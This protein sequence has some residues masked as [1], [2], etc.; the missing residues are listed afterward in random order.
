MYAGPLGFSP[1]MDRIHAQGVQA[2]LYL[3]EPQRSENLRTVFARMVSPREDAVFV[4]QYVV[5]MVACLIPTQTAINEQFSTE[6]ANS[7]SYPGLEPVGGFSSFANACLNAGLVPTMIKLMQ[8]DWS[9]DQ[10]RKERYISQYRALQGLCMLL[11]TGNVSEQ[12]SL[13]EALLKE[14]VVEIC[15]R[16]L[17]HRLCI[18]R[19]AAISALHGLSHSFLGLYISSSTAAHIVESVCTY[20]LRGPKHVV[21]QLNDS[22]TAWQSE[23]FSEDI[24]GGQEEIIRFVP[25]YYA[26]AQDLAVYTAH[27]ILCT[28]PS[29]SQDFCLAALKE[30]PHIL[31]LLLYCA[32]INRPT[33]YPESQMKATSL[34]ALIAL[35]QWPCHTV[36]GSPATVGMSTS[37]RKIMSQ[38]MSVLTSRPEWSD[39]LI[40]VWMRLQEEDLIHAQRYLNSSKDNGRDPDSPYMEGFKKFFRSRA[41][42][43]ASVLR[44]IATFTHA[45][46]PCGITNA[47]IE[48]FLHIAYFGCRKGGKD[49]KDCSSAV[50]AIGTFE[51]EE[52]VYQM[53]IG[54]AC[55]DQPDS[56]DSPFV[57]A[58][59][60]VLGPIALIRLFVV[61]AQRKALDS[62]QTLRKA[63][64]GLSSSTSLAQIQVIT[65]PDV[66]RRAIEISQVRILERLDTGR[67]Y[68]E[69]TKNYACVIF[70]SAAEL[71]AAVV[72][73]DEHTEGRYMAEARGARKQLVIALGNASQM[74]LKLEHYQ[75]ALRLADAAIGVAEN[76]P[77]EENLNP[78]IT[79][80]NKRRASQATAG[81]QRK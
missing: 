59:Q 7:K 45:A 6:M 18:M 20:A 10:V 81:L 44:L 52:D 49:I 69:D 63:P 39:K 65:H 9:G 80:K 56:V 66:I 61:L 48:S 8:Q 11:R 5:D 74:A 50:E 1:V 35:F 33:A 53:P 27:G 34:E 37:E 77:A 73:L 3:P 19:Q 25:K 76:I 31:D 43:R 14:G 40:E 71:A 51:Y 72:A 21:D 2:A 38:S 17:K 4:K 30:R 55:M 32:T 28:F 42:C 68:A 78:E 79:E 23:L 16:Y 64:I 62:I 58:P 57:V 70:M 67:D 60:C 29:R 36:P 75:K 41:V 13:V 15:I 47:Q 22:A 12:Q 54:S 26:M 46:D 24:D